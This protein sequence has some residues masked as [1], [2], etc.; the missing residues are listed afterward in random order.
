[1]K[2]MDLREGFKVGKGYVQALFGSG[3]GKTAMALGRAIEDAGEN[4]QIII[5]QFLKGKL[6]PDGVEHMLKRMEPEIK[7]FSFEKYAACFKDLS[8]EEQEEEKSNIQNGVNFARKVLTTGECDVLILDEF[9][10]VMDMGIVS[11]DDFIRLVQEKDES[12]E[13]IMTGRN[14]PESYYQYVDVVLRIDSLKS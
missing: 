11:R 10:G 2:S 5:I 1:M 13:V 8:L 6:K 12:T 14:F 9:L 4:K 3:S 7:V